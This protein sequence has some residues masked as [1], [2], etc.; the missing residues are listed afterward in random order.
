MPGCNVSVQA[1]TSTQV[2]IRIL[3]L[4]LEC[5]KTQNL[6]NIA[7]GV[8][9]PI[10]ID[11]LTLSLYH[12]L[13]ARVLVEVDLSKPLP[14]KILVTKK[15]AS[16]SNV[17]DFF[18]DIEVEKIPKFCECCQMIGHEMSNCRNKSDTLEMS[19]KRFVP[20]IKKSVRD[21]SN[22][23]VQRIGDE[24]TAAEQPQGAA[25]FNTIRIRAAKRSASA[26]RSMQTM[27]H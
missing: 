21:H 19:Q 25:A 26:I 4:P 2:W 20:A 14:Q 5:R 27:D 22:L 24:K 13:Y 8:G 12:G 11:P 1:Q 16:N 9:L 6:L 10:K 23:T 17:F 7:M 15:D 3:N 18:V